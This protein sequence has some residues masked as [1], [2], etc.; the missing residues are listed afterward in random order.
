MCL[1]TFN[2]HSIHAGL[3][4]KGNVSKFTV[5]SSGTDEKY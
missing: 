4:V 3:R 5:L 1:G 2:F